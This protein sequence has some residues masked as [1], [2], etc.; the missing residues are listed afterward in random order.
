VKSKFKVYLAGAISGQ[1]WGVSTDWRND[2]VR[3]LDDYSGGRIEG[4]SP[5]RAKDFLKSVDAI[6]DSYA[7][8]PL[9]TSRGIMTRDHYD[10]Q[11]ADLVFVNLSGA[12]KVS[13]GTV[14]EIAWA[15]AY[16]T[17][18]I[19]VRDES[20]AHDHAMINEAVCYWADDVEDACALAAKILLP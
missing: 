2:A 13:I 18:I 11:S 4:Y 7:D 3:L 1:S 15:Y 19:M 14:M 20:G 10:C 8:H 17:P 6:A 9:A 16:R 12:S 5:L